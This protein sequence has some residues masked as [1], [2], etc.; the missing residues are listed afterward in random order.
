M[1]QKKGNS[2]IWETVVGGVVSESVYLSDVESSLGDHKD[3]QA[4][5]GRDQSGADAH[6]GSL[7][8]LGNRPLQPRH[9]AHRQRQPGLDISASTTTETGIELSYDE[10]Q[11][12]VPRMSGITEVFKAFLHTT[13]KTN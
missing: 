7:R 5:K 3:G 12:Q 1:R 4:S 8:L 10:S 13:F 2:K 11:V 6:D 9:G